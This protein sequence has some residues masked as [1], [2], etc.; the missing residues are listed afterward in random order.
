MIIREIFIYMIPDTRQEMEFLIKQFEYQIKSH[1]FPFIKSENQKEI[2]NQTITEIKLENQNQNKNEKFIKND[3]FFFLLYKIF[4]HSEFNLAHLE[5]ILKIISTYEISDEFFNC[6]IEQININPQKNHIKIANSNK[7]NLSQEALI[8]YPILNFLFVYN[9][10]NSNL[11]K[12]FFEELDFLKE[13]LPSS[14]NNNNND[15]YSSI[16]NNINKN[17]SNSICNNYK[18]SFINNKF[19]NAKEESLNFINNKSSSYENHIFSL[20]EV[21]KICSSCLLDA[22]SNNLYSESAIISL[23]PNFLKNIVIMLLKIESESDKFLNYFIFEIMKKIKNSDFLELAIEVYMEKKDF[24]KLSNLVNSECYS[25]DEELT[26]Y[27]IYAQ[28]ICILNDGYKWNLNN[29][30]NKKCILLAQKPDFHIYYYI[31]LIQFA[32]K[33]KID[34]SIGLTVINQFSLVYIDLIKNNGFEKIVFNNFTF[35]KKN[36]ENKSNL[37]LYDKITNLDN[38]SS[39][40]FT[41]KNKNLS[42][43]LISLDDDQITNNLSKKKL[44][45]TANYFIDKNENNILILDILLEYFNW[46]YSIQPDFIFS[47]VICDLINQIGEYFELA[48][49]NQTIENYFT[50]NLRNVYSLINYLLILKN[51]NNKK[52]Y[53]MFQ[54]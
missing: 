49:F 6:F 20:F 2:N 13:N 5:D 4:H 38:A 47:P 53:S 33:K 31:K 23:I 9:F 19:N 24:I 45:K 26:A 46:I 22:Y 34:L 27:V 18:L 3:E 11:F 51:N 17:I 21:L 1:K 48:F 39:F 8:N 32:I 10:F 16:R 15:Y 14:H 41:N 52:K 50:S 40:V 29:I 54:R 28:L 43:N 12:E 7:V 37:L 42:Q 35:V 36:L 25:K 44:L 30:L